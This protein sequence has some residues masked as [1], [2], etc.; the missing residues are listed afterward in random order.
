MERW[1][2]A[3]RAGTSLDNVIPVN[4]APSRESADL[5]SSRLDLI[6]SRLLDVDPDSVKSDV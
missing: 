6:R 1:I 4:V 2:E 5:L 3:V